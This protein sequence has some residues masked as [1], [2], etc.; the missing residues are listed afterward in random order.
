MTS[1]ETEIDIMSE[2]HIL[3]AAHLVA[4]RDVTGPDEAETVLH[5]GAAH[6]V[7]VADAVT[8]ADVTADGAR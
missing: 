5:D 3:Q 6:A 2:G 4:E 7:V 1:R 8:D